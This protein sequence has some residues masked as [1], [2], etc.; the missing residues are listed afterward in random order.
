MSG[1]EKTWRVDKHWTLHS[2]DYRHEGEERMTAVEAVAQAAVLNE[3]DA[4][5]G[6]KW[7]AVEAG[8]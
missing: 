1:D 6:V 8:K 4:G 5:R 7:V 2:T 3:R